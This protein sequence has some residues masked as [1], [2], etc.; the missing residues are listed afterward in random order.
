MAAKQSAEMRHAL[1]L[2]EAGATQE[3]AGM[4]AGVTARAIRYALTKIIVKK[5]KK[6]LTKRK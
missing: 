5:S 4:K 2:I 1:S 6:I 3:S